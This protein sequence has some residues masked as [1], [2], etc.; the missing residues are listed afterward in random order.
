MRVFR[1]PACRSAVFPH[2]LA[3]GACGAALVWSVD[4]AGFAAEAMHCANRDEINCNWAAPA[5]GALCWAC[6]MT[7]VIPDTFHGRNLSLW[8]EAERA[9]RQVL[10]GLGRWG[11][12]RPDDPGPLPSFRM[13][14]EETRDGRRN[15]VMAHNRGIITINVV[16]ADLAERIDRRLALGEKMRT[17]T[18]HFRHELAHLIFER[19]SA[20]QRFLAEFRERMGDERL[21][22]VQALQVYYDTGPPPGWESDYIT[23]Y[24]SAHPHEDWAETAAHV[25]HLT[26]IIDS[27]AAIGLCPAGQ[28]LADYDAYAERE[29]GR[30]VALGTQLSIA[31]NHINRSIGIGDLYPFVLRDGVREKL[32]FVHGWLA[33]GPREGA[34]GDTAAQ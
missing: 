18:G 19:L 25:M 17:M 22:Y 15:V 26:D 31:V 3:C 10:A 27:A 5:P 28:T 13:L 2:D 1:C 11:W 4:A 32:A 34:R 8:T 29:A 12:F 21:D 30:I 14:S 6:E 16:E 9:K 24:A 23:R 20:D 7:E 33:A